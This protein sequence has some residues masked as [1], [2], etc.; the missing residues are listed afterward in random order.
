MAERNIV[1]GP[2]CAAYDADRRRFPGGEVYTYFGN[3]ADGQC[4]P[5]SHEDA[6]LR[7]STQKQR[8]WPGDDRREVGESTKPKEYQGGQYVPEGEPEMK[9]EPKDA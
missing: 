6:H 4:S 9:G 1:V 2:S 7:R 8:L 3:Q 5:E